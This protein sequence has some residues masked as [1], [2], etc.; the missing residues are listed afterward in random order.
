MKKLT[1]A[2]KI[3]ISDWMR[4][5]PDEVRTA[6]VSGIALTLKADTGLDAAPSTITHIARELGIR[7]DNR[8]AHRGV[9]SAANH[10][11]VAVVLAKAIRQLADEMGVH[12]GT[13][14][15][16]NS[17]VARAQFKPGSGISP[18]PDE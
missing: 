13:E 9:F 8:G 2:E 4:K 14:E 10:Y 18:P 16:L 3:Q 7:T 11:D 12:L 1:F 5:H 17:I 6:T 15:Q